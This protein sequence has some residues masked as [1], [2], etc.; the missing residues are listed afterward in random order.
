M[1]IRNVVP[2]R[3]TQPRQL[4]LDLLAAA[5]RVPV[6]VRALVEAGRILGLK[7]N[8]MRVALSRLRAR[9]AVV[10]PTRGAYVL[11]PSA[12]PRP[13]TPWKAGDEELLA[14]W[15]GASWLAVHEL[16][17]LPE[18]LRWLGF[19]PVL[20]G[21]SLRPANLRGGAPA[22][23]AELGPARP[24]FVVSALDPAPDAEALWDV[25]ARAMRQAALA[26]A[27]EDGFA[28]IEDAAPSDDAALATAFRLGGQ[29]L[30][31][32]HLD[33]RLPPAL[34]PAEPRRRL[35]AAMRRYDRRARALWS[36]RLG[37]EGATPLGRVDGGR[38]EREGVRA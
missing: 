36:A 33:P 5:G 20:R 25:H 6:D 26:R 35:Q 1:R 16:G 12:P 28:T 17:A 31:S 34:A 4:V 38:S 22:L 21:L 29:A 8:A 9:E 2:V 32:L 27:L 18:P 13:P 14:P 11:G 23:R 24:V 10:S 37:L 30:R 7:E 15:D 19:R 3:L